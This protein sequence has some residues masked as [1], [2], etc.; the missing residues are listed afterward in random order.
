MCVV[1]T[2]LIVLEQAIELTGRSWDWLEGY[3][4]DMEGDGRVWKLAE[5]SV[6]VTIYQ[7]V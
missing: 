1:L 6:S 5:C 4:K 7:H 3:W 2:L